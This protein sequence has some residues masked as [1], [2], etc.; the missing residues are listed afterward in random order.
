LPKTRSRSCFSTTDPA[1]FRSHWINTMYRC[2]ALVLA[3]CAWA[4]PAAAQVSRNFPQNALRGEIA[5]GYPPE[6]AVNGQ[7]ARLSPGSRIRGLNNML[8]LSGTLAGARATVNYTVDDGGQIRDVWILRPEEI[9]NQPWPTTVQ[10]A[11]A[12]A[13][14]PIAQVW[15]KR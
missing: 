9:A 15:T 13:F 8:E 14:D 3:V 4:L 2:L 5:F 10:E 1:P 12:W 11:Q 7:A 6:V